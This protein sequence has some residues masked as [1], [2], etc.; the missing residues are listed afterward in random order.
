MPIWLTPTVLRYAGAAV[1][2]LMLLLGVYAKGRH[3]VQVKFNAYK[4][5]VKL[6]AEEQAR[7]SAK[8]DAKN[9]KLFKETQDAYNTQLANL[10]AYYLMRNNGKGLGTVPQV[11]SAPAGADGYSPDNLP[12]TPVLASQCA[13]TTLNLIALQNFVRGAMNNAE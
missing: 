13:E 5:E 8:V 11:S 2:T 12:P 3:D 10:R 9:L 7:E 1:I 4:A 6:A